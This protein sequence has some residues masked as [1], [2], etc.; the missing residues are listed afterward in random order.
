M[1]RIVGLA[2]LFVVGVAAPAE[3]NE[4]RAGGGTSI[5]AHEGR[6]GPGRD[7]SLRGRTTP[8]PRTGALAVGQSLRPGMS[9]ADSSGELVPPA[10]GLAA[11][12]P[13]RRAGGVS[14]PWVSQGK[15]GLRLP[16]SQRLSFALGY[17]HVE[18]EDLARRYA[19]SGSVDYDSHDFLLR[20]H[21]RF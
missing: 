1:L 9:S 15:T 21:W 18:P 17:R 14:L 6:S 5:A 12:P 20:A 19:D 2:L 4:R 11:L 8:M 7:T 16:V 13:E 3:A 10:V